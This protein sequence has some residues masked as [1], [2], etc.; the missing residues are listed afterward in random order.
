MFHIF[1]WVAWSFVW[2]TKPTN[3]PVATGLVLALVKQFNLAS[4]I[5]TFLTSRY[6]LH[7]SSFSQLVVC[8]RRNLLKAANKVVHFARCVKHKTCTIQIYRT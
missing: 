3:P 1:I 2:G 7:V 4:S 6:H 5:E 8:K